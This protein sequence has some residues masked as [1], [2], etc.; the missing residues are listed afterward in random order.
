MLLKIAKE[1]TRRINV[2]KKEFK[3]FYLKYMFYH[4]QISNFD[5]F[6]I[7]ERTFKSIKAPFIS[8]LKNRCIV[9]YR[10]RAPLSFFKLSRIVFKKKGS[11]GELTGVKKAS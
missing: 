7:K 3:N 6:L 1:K 8:Q 5:R 4:P 11:F 10:A 2:V 9:S